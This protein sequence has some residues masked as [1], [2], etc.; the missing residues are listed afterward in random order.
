[1][2]QRARGST[3]V[4]MLVLLAILGVIAG[5]T[6]L[7]FRRPPNRAAIDAVGTRALDARRKAV[8]SG[9]S[10]TVIVWRDGKPMAL[11]AHADGRV[12]ADTALA[13]DPLSGRPAR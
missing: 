5:V 12:V 11:T 7:S 13:I 1:M 2:R 4:E 9:R 6:G 10:L 3:L 8:R